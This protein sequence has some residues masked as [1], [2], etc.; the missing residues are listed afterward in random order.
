LVA[1]GD[2]IDLQHLLGH[3]SAHQYSA[4]LDASVAGL[5]KQAAF[6]A[7]WLGREFGTYG[8]AVVLALVALGL[9]ALARRDR[10]L[11]VAALLLSVCN[12]ALKLVYGVAEDQDA[13]LLPLAVWLAFV[14]GFGAEWILAAGARRDVRA[15]AAAVVL[16]VPALSFWENRATCDRSRFFVADDLVADTFES[17]SP[18]GL[19]LTS[20]WQLFSPLLYY[21]EI[22]GRR[23]DVLPIDVSLLRRAWY[24]DTLRR[25][26]PE[27][28]QRADPSVV[29]FLED[30][31]AWE[32]DPRLYARDGVLNRR[33]DERFHAMVLGLVDAHR[34]PVYATSDVVLPDFTPDPGLARS[35]LGRFTLAPRGLVFELRRDAGFR[36]PGE[37][38]FRARGLFDGTL[39]FEPDD[40]ALTKVRPVYI[41]MI[42]NRGR[43][44]E[45]FGQNARAERD[46]LQTLAWDP[47]QVVAAQGLAR[48][49]A[50]VP[51]QP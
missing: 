39:R 6:V 45:A 2:P 5:G 10:S 38:S 42:A 1:W 18:N 32:R 46:Y 8:S 9:V 16:A 35:L 4:F 50:G 36:D 43:Y 48:I 20:E 23:R 19:L 51:S 34:G 12:V 26:A 31:R 30:L 47:N 13:Y 14:A 49:R 21:R 37:S 40:V 17:V 11:F 22:E 33:I 15:L 29:P 27:L 41:N 25:Q 44:L 28:M 3:V 24:F 7:T